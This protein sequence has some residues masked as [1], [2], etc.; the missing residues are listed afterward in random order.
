MLFLF[1]IN[2]A[3]EIGDGLGIL[4]IRLREDQDY[5]KGIRQRIAGAKDVCALVSCLHMMLLDAL[6]LLA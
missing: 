2:D 3:C 5:T 4:G 1:A 6:C